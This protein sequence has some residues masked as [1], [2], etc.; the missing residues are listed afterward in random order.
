MFRS[1]RERYHA[2]REIDAQAPW[3]EWLWRRYARFW[4]GIGCLFVDVV[5]A[6]TLV[7]TGTTSGE[8]W[9]YAAAVAAVVA[10]TY[11][12]FKGYGRLWPVGHRE[13]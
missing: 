8:V 3:R 9:P 10:L 7:Q 4:Y 2:N 13:G 5:V 1:V 6:G 11:L 12:E